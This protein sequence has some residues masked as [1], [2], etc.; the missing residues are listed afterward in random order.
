MS[1]PAYANNQQSF[2]AMYEQSLVG[3][4]FR[5]WAEL[6]LDRLRPAAGD[7][8]LAIACGTGIGARLAHERVG[9]GGV[10]VGV[11]VSPGMLEVARAVAPTITWRDG[12]A[13]DLPLADGERF[14]VVTCQQGLQFF[15]DRVVAARQ[16]RGALAPGGRLGV[17]TWRPADEIPMF[18]ALQPVA[19]R[20]LGPVVDQRHAFGD[21]GQL[22]GLLEDAGF[23]DVMV[24]T[25]TRRLRF[26]D[27]VGFVRMNT[28]ALVGMSA[29]GKTMSDE[30]RAATV[31]AIVADSADI[32]R[33]FSDGAAAVFDISSNVAT[34]RG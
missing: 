18:R 8:V 5:P 16:M 30:T 26:D 29:A 14:D 25:V 15:P 20:H 13:L 33:S 24:D 22:G 4:L 19:E 34:A 17:A 7:R 27:G 9:P 1:L 2:P 31:A 10:V 32:L 3:P 12:S 23:G 21:G 6:M 28:M 11:D